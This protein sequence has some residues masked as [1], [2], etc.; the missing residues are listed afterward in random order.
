MLAVPNPATTLPITGNPLPVPP[1]Q[2]AIYVCEAMVDL[3]GARP[4]STFEPLSKVF[5]GVFRPEAP[6][7]VPKFFVAGIWPDYARQ[8][9]AIAIA[10]SDYERL[11]GDSRVNDLAIWLDANAVSSDVEQAETN[12]GQKLIGVRPQFFSF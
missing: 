2:I 11:T 7:N 1:G 9:G 6:D 12:W 4:G 3:Y 5:S 8:F 10:K